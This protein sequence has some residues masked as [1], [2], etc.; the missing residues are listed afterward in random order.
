MDEDGVHGSMDDTDEQPGTGTQPSPI[1]FTLLAMNYSTV[2]EIL[3]AGC[4]RAGCGTFM[5]GET[6]KLYRR[7]LNSRMEQR[8]SQAIFY[9]KLFT[10]VC[11]S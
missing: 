6:I 11:L 4:S 5:Q 3:H 2:H 7:L 9:Q 8:S 1:L 10:T